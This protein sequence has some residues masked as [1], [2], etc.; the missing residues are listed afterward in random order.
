[1]INNAS[2]V[3]MKLCKMRRVTCDDK[4]VFIAPFR[5]R[6]ANRIASWLFEKWSRSTFI[7]ETAYT[8]LSLDTDK[9]S[10]VIFESERG[11]AQCYGVRGGT[12]Y[13]GPDEFRKAMA[14]YCSKAE[15]YG[16]FS[17]RIP[18]RVGFGS[19]VRFFGMDVKMLPWMEG[20]LIVPKDEK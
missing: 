12:V 18:M 2:I 13:M 15:F 4:R 3:Q 17:V 8:V 6:W 11:L 1:M 16:P 10:R 19:E 9:L 14:E 20:I 7:D 5:W